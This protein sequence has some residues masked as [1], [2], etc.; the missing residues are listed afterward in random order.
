MVAIGYKIEAVKQACKTDLEI[1]HYLNDQ[2]LE[3][4]KEHLGSVYTVTL[5]EVRGKNIEQF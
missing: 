4:Q 1:D 2:V 3:S 5:K